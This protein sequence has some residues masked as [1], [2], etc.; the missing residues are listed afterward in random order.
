MRASDVSAGR[1][2][3]CDGIARSA[4]T[5][6]GAGNFDTSGTSQITRESHY[7]AFLLDTE[8][9]SLTQSLTYSADINAQQFGGLRS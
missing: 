4:A 5:P 8:Q 1:I 7:F 6:G 9:G 3:V 2:S